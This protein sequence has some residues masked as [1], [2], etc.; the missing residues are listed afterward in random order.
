MELFLNLIGWVGSIW[1]A[2][3]RQ[4][5]DWHGHDCFYDTWRTT[6]FRAIFRRRT[7][8]FTVT[9]FTFYRLLPPSFLIFF[10]SWSIYSRLHMTY[11]SM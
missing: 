9:P 6:E 7:R 8:V 1:G 10:F 5:Q 3:G 2:G 4:R 11:E